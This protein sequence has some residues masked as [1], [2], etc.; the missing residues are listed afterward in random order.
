MR[1]TCSGA[2]PFSLIM[3][4]GLV[5][6]V[7][8]RIMC[9]VKFRFDDLVVVVVEEILDV[10]KDL[11]Q[12]VRAN[13]SEAATVIGEKSHPKNGADKLEIMDILRVS[14]TEGEAVPALRRTISLP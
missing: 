7:H 14:V 9:I 11:F 13:G 5:E 8:N 12:K 2:H 6:A 10:R 4:C 1:F 3:Q